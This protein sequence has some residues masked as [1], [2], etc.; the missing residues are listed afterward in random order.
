M[1]KYLALL[2]VTAALAAC[3]GSD[4]GPLP[5]AA[6]GG[7]PP[8]TDP[9]PPPGSDEPPAPPAVIPAIPAGLTLTYSAK[10]YDFTWTAGA[11]VSGYR[12]IE[13]ADGAG[14]D[15]SAQ[16]GTTTAATFAYVPPLLHTRLAAH[17]RVQACNAAGCSPAS[18]AISPDASKA[19]GYFKAATPVSGERFGH[20]IAV[21]ADGSTLAVGGPNANGIT[22]AVLV[23][24]RGASGWGAPV[25]LLAANAGVGDNFGAALA[26]SDDGS[27]LAVGA[28]GEASGIA[29][30]PTDNGAFGAGAVYIFR[31]AS[32]T[33][34]Q[35]A[36]VKAHNPAANRKF[37]S[38]VALSAD[39]NT[40]ATGAYFEGSGNAGVYPAAALPADNN[41]AGFSGAVHVHRR[42]GAAWSLDTYIKAWNVGAN[43]SFGY[44]VALSADGTTLA[45]GSSMERNEATGVHAATALPAA[46]TGAAAAGAAYVYRASGGAWALES[47]IK[48][49]NT[50]AGDQFGTVLTLSGDGNTLA[51]GAP[52]EDSNMTGVSAAV[53]PDNNAG[54][55]TGAV[56]LYNR[57]GGT[58][59]AGAYVKPAQS[60]NNYLFG[61]ALSLSGDGT[62]LAVGASTDGS[63]AR[64]FGG[65]MGSGASDSGAVHTFARSGAT[66]APDTFLKASNTRTAANFAS[67][68]AW[69]R[70]GNALA[71]GAAQEPGTAGGVRAGVGLTDSDGAT[72]DSGAAYLY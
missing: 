3:G 64:G 52:R 71:V 33:W 34:S 50:G 66:W 26:L 55:T 2:F 27:T 44:A 43:A 62:R 68:V 63:S 53:P 4:D 8:V 17:Y 60:Y 54:N 67:S 40:L 47:Y 7:D 14:P 9:A 51:V 38:A 11:G 37:G 22:G 49:G 6:G 56:Y 70:D 13:D 42:V 15:G 29:A 61:L 72:A 59:S 32:G 36:Y 35:E 23:Y 58:W 31:R 5:P 19:I 21:S 20:A 12:I 24:A 57:A 45:A 65:A 46:G 39:G 41:A 69:S 25:Q 28:N 18:E 48:A 16:V 1:R 30:D 10:G